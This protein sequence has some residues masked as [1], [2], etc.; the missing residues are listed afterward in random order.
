MEKHRTSCSE[1]MSSV[2]AE[3]LR[4]RKGCRGDLGLVSPPAMMAK[5]SARSAFNSSASGL[6][7]SANPL[8]IA[9]FPRTSTISLF[10]GGMDFRLEW[11]R[12]AS[13]KNGRR[14]SNNETDH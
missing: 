13:I 2:R 4:H 10:Y 8:E 9:L 6:A 3:D 14:S 7:N 5:A 11:K 1:R 12:N